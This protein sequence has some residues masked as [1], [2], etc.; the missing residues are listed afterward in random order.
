MDV[1]TFSNSKDTDN[2]CRPS[3]QTRFSLSP[4]ARRDHGNRRYLF[5]ERGFLEPRNS[6]IFPQINRLF[7]KISKST[8]PRR[9]ESCAHQRQ[10]AMPLHG[11]LHSQTTM[12][13]Y[14]LTRTH[15]CARART[16]THTCIYNYICIYRHKKIPISGLTC[17]RND[18]VVH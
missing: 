2:L 10:L 12:R 4:G 8:H 14:T 7:Q 11:C 1:K 9:A 17:A 6:P 5:A 13:M 15:A 18:F 16:H 3:I